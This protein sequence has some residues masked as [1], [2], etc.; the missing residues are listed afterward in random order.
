M[1]PFLTR[2]KSSLAIISSFATFPWNF[3]DRKEMTSLSQFFPNTKINTNSLS[4][5]YM[6]CFSYILK[7]CL[8]KEFKSHLF[9][10]YIEIWLIGK[11]NLYTK[12]IFANLVFMTT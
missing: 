8:F 5:H 3:F 7:A 1:Q 6:I 2:S 12:V 4:T 9:S 11:S 10:S